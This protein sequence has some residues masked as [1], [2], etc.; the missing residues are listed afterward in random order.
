MEGGTFFWPL[1]L[2]VH[3]HLDGITP[4]GLDLG[5]RERSI[6][7]DHAPIDTIRGY[8][9]AGNGHIISAY[10]SCEWRNLVRVGIES[11]SGSPWKA[12][13]QRRLIWIRHWIPG[14]MGG[15]SSHWRLEM[16]ARGGC[17][18]D[19]ASRHLAQD[20]VSSS[21][22]TGQGS[23]AV[24]RTIGSTL[25]KSR[26]EV[27]DRRKERHLELGCW[28]P[29][30]ALSIA[31]ATRAYRQFLTSSKRECDRLEAFFIL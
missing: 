31:E 28:K 9:A 6:D 10:D 26:D 19:R 7:Q 21:C 11:S 16:P 12:I 14:A 13:R 25:C 1:D 8:V 15:V 3:S 22:C 23:N 27:G 24:V 30:K 2:V 17:S 20:R 4:V 18:V 5:S 29:N